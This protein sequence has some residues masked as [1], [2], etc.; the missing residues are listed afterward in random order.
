MRGFKGLSRSIVDFLKDR[1]SCTWQIK[2][3]KGRQADIESRIGG[4]KKC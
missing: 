2:E 1:R 3:R 4:K